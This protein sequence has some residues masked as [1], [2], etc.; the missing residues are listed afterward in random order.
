MCALY[1]MKSGLGIWI[2]PSVCVCVCAVWG[3]KGEP[4]VMI[5]IWLEF[6]E[7]KI[8]FVRGGQGGVAGLSGGLG[9]ATHVKMEAKEDPNTYLNRMFPVN[10]SA[11][12]YTL[13]WS[14]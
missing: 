7:K 11:N 9:G 12:L 13:T 8:F 3:G 1:V 14:S 4:T 6:S 5:R 10:S 2:W